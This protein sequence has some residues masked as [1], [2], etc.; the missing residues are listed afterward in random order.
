[1]KHI[2]R[3]GKLISAFMF[4]LTLVILISIIMSL[5]NSNTPSVFGYSM[6][7]VVSDSM[8]DTIKV[9]DFIII[10]NKK[11]Y[12]VGD[13]VTFYGSINNV[14]ARITHRIIVVN[15]EEGYYITQGDKFINDIRF[16]HII[17]YTETV[18]YDDVIGKVVFISTFLGKLLSLKF[19]QNKNL[20]FLVIFILLLFIVIILMRNLYLIIKTRPEES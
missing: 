11:E 5:K 7:I 16:G 8:E 9:N 12:K 18:P 2:K 19:F 17:E 1:M 6:L 10:K 20:I 13:I 15:E 4:S 3:L 14:Q